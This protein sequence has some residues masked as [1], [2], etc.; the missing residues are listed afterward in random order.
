MAREKRFFFPPHVVLA[1]VYFYACTLLLS[2]PPHENSMASND[3]HTLL[4][5]LSDTFSF[6]FSVVVPLTHP[7]WCSVCVYVCVC[8]IYSAAPLTRAKGT[9]KQHYVRSPQ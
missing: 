7:H 1:T 6:F 3:N 2:F 5:S 4:V 9:R 8:V